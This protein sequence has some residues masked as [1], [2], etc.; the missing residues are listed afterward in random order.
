M[1]E[2][3]NH[4]LNV[5]DKPAFLLRIM[6]ELAGGAKMSLEGDLAKCEFAAEVILGHDETNVLKRNT[7]LPKQ[8]FIVLDLEPEVIDSI[9]KQIMAAGLSRTIV[10]VQIER[11]GILELGAYDNFHPDCVVTRSGISTELLTELKSKHILRDFV[12]AKPNV[13]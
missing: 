11:D 4:W 2:A 13:G 1:A 9:F 5:R 8:D 3:I 7:I 12:V 10:H 6:Q